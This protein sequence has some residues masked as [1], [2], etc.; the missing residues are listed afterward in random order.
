MTDRKIK[1]VHVHPP[2]PAR[3]FDYMAY[4]EDQEGNEEALVGYGETAEKAVD[5]LRYIAED[6]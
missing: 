5:D 6:E 1:T 4:F 2:I 3:M